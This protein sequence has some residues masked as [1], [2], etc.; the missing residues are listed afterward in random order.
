M[1]GSE[2]P[3]HLQERPGSH[4]QPHQYFTAD[5]FA[6]RLAALSGKRKVIKTFSLILSDFFPAQKK[7]VSLTSLTSHRTAA[8]QR[9]PGNRMHAPRLLH[10]PLTQRHGNGWVSGCARG[11]RRITS[12]DAVCLLS[13]RLICELICTCVCL[14][15]VAVCIVQVYVGKN[16]SGV[17]N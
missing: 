8:L 12:S 1:H 10:H 9:P 14:M 11:S 17:G 13:S 15:C 7:N 5:T 16:F 3:A 2:G 6:H 4:L